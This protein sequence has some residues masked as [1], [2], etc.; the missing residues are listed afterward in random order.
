VRFIHA[1]DVHLDSPLTG[2]DRYEG[3][4]SEEFRLAT[5]G[6]LE[7]LVTLCLDESASFLI[8]A[9]DL[10][11]GGW[12]DYNTGLFFAKQMVRLRDGGVRVLV[13][14]GN[15][16]ADSEITRTLPWPDNVFVFPTAR[17]ATKVYEDLSVAVHGQGF[18][19][20]KITEDLSANYP[21]AISGMLNIGVLHT[22]L[23][24]REGH[25]AY[26]PTTADALARKGY[27]YWALGHVHAREVVQESPWIVFPGNL[28]GRHVRETGAKGATLVTVERGKIA[29]VEHRVCDV[30]RWAV[31]DVDAGADAQGSVEA[32]LVRAAGEAEGRPVAARVRI[33]G[34]TPEHA[35]IRGDL[36]RFENEVRAIALRIR[37]LWVEKIEV[38]TRAPA[39]AA[40]SEA[41]QLLAEEIASLKGSNELSQMIERI[42]EKLP[43]AVKKIETETL[44]ED[45]EAILSLRLYAEG[46]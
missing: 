6:A 42:R 43:A 18:V 26:A 36:E 39:E 27:D 4:P 13:L 25:D 10:Y 11:D 34:A 3:A 38:L 44:L 45:A 22:A 12:N 40:G 28:Q 19:K 31:C 41:A 8:I 14:S 30:V 24:G 21:A 15:H 37:G 9:G 33:R 35:K 2:L 20:K 7:N 16:D 29:C 1:A 32:A 5:R 17:A 46:E 23:D